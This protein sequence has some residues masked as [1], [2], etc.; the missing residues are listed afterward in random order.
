M[1]DPENSS[2]KL[3][4]YLP[5]NL[6]D[7]VIVE[8]KK[9]PTEFLM[10]EVSTFLSQIFIFFTCAL[11]SSN[12][13]RNE[14]LLFKY[15]DVKLKNIDVNET[16]ILVMASLTAIG[17]LKLIQKAAPN[18]SFTIK[19]I[20]SVINQLPKFFYTLS[21]SF[22]GIL[23]AII[24]FVTNNPKTPDNLGVP[25]YSFF[26]V[27]TFIYGIMCGTGLAFLLNHKNLINK[28]SMKENTEHNPTRSDKK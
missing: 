27:V 8:R 24:F 23:I 21:A 16:I 2:R 7:Q 4:T 14:T 5:K 10:I 15:I 28:N 26:A 13:L 6:R 18:E 3:S 17:L 20:D 9:T 11:Y 1:H 22:I 12:F 25:A 19:I